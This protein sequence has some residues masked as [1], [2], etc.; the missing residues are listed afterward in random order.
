[1]ASR[2][3]FLS[4]IILVIHSNIHAQTIHRAACDGN[5]GQLDSLL[6]TTDINITNGTESTALQLAAYCRQSEAFHFLLEKGAD[7]H[8]TNRFEETALYYAIRARDSAMVQSLI[9]KGALLDI[10]NEENISPLFRTVQSDNL[11][12]LNMLL[13]A[14][15]DI[16]L[17]KSPL[18]DA[19]LND[20]L[21]ILRLIIDDST[22]LDP[23]N[24][25]KN[26]PLAIAQ[27]QGSTEIAEFLISK[28][29]D[30]KKVQEF[31]LSG[32][33]AGQDMPGNEAVIFAPGFISAENFVHT[34]AFNADQTK[35]YYTLESWLAHGGTIMVTSL[36]DGKWT[37][38]VP[39]DIEG[40]Y[41]EID[42]FITRDGKWLYYSSNRPV[43]GVEDESNIDMWMVNIEEDSWSEPIYLGAK[44]NT[45]FLDWFPTLS[46]NGNLY[47]STGPNP[48]SNIVLSKFEDGEYQE[49]VSLGDSVNSESRDYD[50]LIAPDESFVIFS[51]NRPGG[52]GSVDLYISYK[53]KDGSWTR[54]KNMGETINTQSA[55]FAS[56]LSYDGKYLFFNR[57]G[58]IFWIDAGIISDLKE[59]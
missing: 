52:F 37:D 35:I 14:G 59:N 10:L 3:L 28:G 8:S 9:T 58:E 50:P 36:I 7:I 48:S 30:E 6:I 16:N 12:L 32:P 17:G 55:E 41:R 51:S 1:M 44:V 26:T 39:S 53:K 21:E 33:Y 20:N 5:L 18:H 34:V 19:V 42:P 23:I 2:S 24:N 25:Y 11:Q 29:A 57:G 46:E 45:E 40:N 15:A 43:N 22:E 38:P 54:A 13:E 49:A 27:R 56:K 4:I 47:F 31:N